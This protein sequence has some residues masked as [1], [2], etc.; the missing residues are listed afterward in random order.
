M[1]DNKKAAA[2]SDKARIDAIIAVLKE[3]GLSLAHHKA[4]AE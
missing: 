1:A 2:S 3:N 4:L